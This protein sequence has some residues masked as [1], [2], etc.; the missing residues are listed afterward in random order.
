MAKSFQASRARFW[1]MFISATSV[2]LR[3]LQDN[4]SSECHGDPSSASNPPA[5]APEFPRAIKKLVRCEQLAIAAV[6]APPPKPK[7]CEASFLPA[8][9]WIWSLDGTR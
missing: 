7:V 6:V 8:A 9:G 1:K 5:F 3:V 2:A 4:Y